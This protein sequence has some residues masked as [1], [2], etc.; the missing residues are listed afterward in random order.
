MNYKDYHP[1][2]QNF[3]RKL[4]AY[5]LEKD[6]VNDSY[7]VAKTL[8]SEI[9]EKAYR[10]AVVLELAINWFKSGGTLALMDLLCNT[11][12]DHRNIV[13]FNAMTLIDTVY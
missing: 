3:K 4:D 5:V 13:H 1:L 11:S 2:A 8:L 12:Y 7:G 6:Q 10:D 9:S